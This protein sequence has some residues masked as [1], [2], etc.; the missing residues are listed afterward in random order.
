[1][2]GTDLSDESYAGFFGKLPV[3]GDFLGR[4]LPD[5]FRL[6]WDAWMAQHLAPIPEPWPAGG[7]RF[8]LQ[9]GTRTAAGLVRPSR[10]AVGRSYPISG[11]IV[12]PCLPD[13]A[14]LDAWC[15]AAN[16]LL[17]AAG[18]GRL[19]P[20]ALWEALET[21]PRPDGAGPQAEEPLLLWTVGQTPEAASPG[22][23]G[24][25]LQRLLSSGLSSSL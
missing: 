6:R 8:R 10:D 23:P 1:M 20:D 18:S 11:L 22:H 15:D 24:P 14:G 21:L 16:P 5:A 12:A 19:D 7:L 25:V 2:S 9:S 4:G 13:P 3:T 17:E